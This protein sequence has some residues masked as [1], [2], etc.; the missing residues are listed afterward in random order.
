M[1]RLLVVSLVAAL[2]TSACLAS[3]PAPPFQVTLRLSPTPA[4]TGPTR[5]IIDVAGVGGNPVTNAAVSVEGL[6]EEH[7]GRA[8]TM[9]MAT[10]EGAGRYVVPDLELDI[11]GPW[12]IAVTVTDST[13]VSMTRS[14]PI[15]VY[16]GS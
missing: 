14:F 2:T 10:E 9:G 11:R 12:T 4:L 3:P 13:G 1:K 5:L 6:P 16:G 7:A 15:S 8:A